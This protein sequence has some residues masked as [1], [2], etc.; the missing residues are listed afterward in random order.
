MSPRDQGSWA[1]RRSSRKLHVHTKVEA[2]AEARRLRLPR[3]WKTRRAASCENRPR[4]PP[5]VF[6]GQARSKRSRFI[7]LAQTATKSFTNF[8]FASE[9]A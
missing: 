7:T 2:L 5:S 4:H 3:G 1:T 8:S 6:P 9:L